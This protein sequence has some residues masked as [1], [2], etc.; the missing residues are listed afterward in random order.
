MKEGLENCTQYVARTHN[1]NT[2]TGALLSILTDRAVLALVGSRSNEETQGA[3][4]WEWP[5]SRASPQHSNER[6]AGQLGGRQ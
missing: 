2:H 6:P 3:V 5:R 4:W 1:A